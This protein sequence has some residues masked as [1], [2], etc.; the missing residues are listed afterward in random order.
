MH[1]KIANI[2]SRY[3]K[4]QICTSVSYVKVC[5]LIHVLRGVG[6]WIFNNHVFN[7][8]IFL[9]FMVLTIRMYVIQFPSQ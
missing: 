9:Y 4:Y 8:M 5:I 1:S 7:S 3:N 6:H 2:L